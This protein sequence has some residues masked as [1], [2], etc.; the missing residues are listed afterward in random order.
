MK[1]YLADANSQMFRIAA[2][3]I[4]PNGYPL[5]VLGSYWYFKDFWADF[6]P[7]IAEFDPDIF[8]DSGAFT[9]DSQG[10]IIN[11]AEYSEW[12]SGCKHKLFHYLNLDVLGNNEAT[13]EHQRQLEALGH[14]PLPVFTLDRTEIRFDL[15]DEMCDKY[16]LICLGNLVSL[17]GSVNKLMPYLI[18]CFRIAQGRTVFH[19]LGLMTWG[20]QKRLPFYSADSSGWG[21]GYRYG[22][23]AVF[24]KTRPRTVK[25]SLIVVDLRAKLASL[26]FDKFAVFYNSQNRTDA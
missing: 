25:Q 17:S 18:K 23:V 13:Q 14:N 12:L 3:S 1:V 11:L 19:G 24:D 16:P 22:N 15:L 26:L 7:P 9:A 6:W 4:T 2:Q 5:R 21:S 10:V 8:A 20:V